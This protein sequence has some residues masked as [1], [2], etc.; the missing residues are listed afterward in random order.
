MPTRTDTQLCAPGCRTCAALRRA[1]EVEVADAGV[2][3]LSLEAVAGLAGIRVADAE[4][5][6]GSAGRLLRSTYVAV[7]ADLQARFARDLWVAPSW[8]EGIAHAL[9]GHLERLARD[10]ARAGFY[11]VEARTAGPAMHEVREVCRARL[12]DVVVRHHRMAAARGAHPP[13]QI[14]YLHGAVV[15]AIGEAVRTGH[16]DR[17]P[18]TLPEILASVEPGAVVHAG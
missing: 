18:A 17:L 14:E 9:R 4:R 13:V 12:V 8:D 3:A 6:A 11:Y 10:P 7:A 2:T 1:A 16:V 15:H 5:H